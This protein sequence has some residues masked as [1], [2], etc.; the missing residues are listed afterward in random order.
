MNKNVV[1]LTYWQSGHVILHHSWYK[2]V[3]Q[4]SVIFMSFALL[5]IMLLI[6]L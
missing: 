3:Q 5:F 6:C 4:T 2:G 1:C